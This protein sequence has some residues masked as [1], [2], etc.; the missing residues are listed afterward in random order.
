VGLAAE[1]LGDLR[2]ER[3]LHQKA[4]A[5]ARHLLQDRSEFALGDEQLVDLGA[6]AH[7]TWRASRC[8]TPVLIGVGHHSGVR[9]LPCVLHGPEGK[10]GVD[11]TVG[12]AKA[13]LVPTKYNLLPAHASFAE[14]A[15]AC[16]AFME[17]V[18]GH[19]TARPGAPPAQ[20]LGHERACPRSP[21]PPASARAGASTPAIAPCASARC[22]TR[23]R[24]GFEDADVWC[25][26]EV[27]SS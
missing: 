8:A 14:L 17:E 19:P 22:A 18:N 7:R 10:G 15:G 2:L 21:T 27:R 5:E 20:T 6:D 13:G 12:I 9:I 23:P 26:A 3:G 25:R 24:P 1:E 16:R 11:A 4:H